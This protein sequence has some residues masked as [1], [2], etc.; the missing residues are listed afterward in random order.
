MGEIRRFLRY[1]YEDDFGFKIFETISNEEGVWEDYNFEAEELDGQTKLFD[2]S[3]L[4][5]EDL[6][7][8]LTTWKTYDRIPKK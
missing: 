1:C 2:E 7:T 4:K 6:K 5:D 8:L 3:K